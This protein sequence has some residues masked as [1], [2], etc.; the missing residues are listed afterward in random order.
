MTSCALGELLKSLAA[1]ID[2]AT[3]RKHSR[4]LKKPSPKGKAIKTS[5][6]F[7]L[8]KYLP[9]ENKNEYDLERAGVCNLNILV[10]KA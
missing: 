3:L 7:Q 8:Q 2:L 1:K 5:L 9:G 4:G 6:M 10:I